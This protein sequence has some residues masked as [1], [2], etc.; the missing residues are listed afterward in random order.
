MNGMNDRAYFH[1]I[2]SCP[3]Y[4]VK[5]GHTLLNK[6]QKMIIYIAIEDWEAI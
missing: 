1:K 3:C 5:L 2:W 4:D 6:I